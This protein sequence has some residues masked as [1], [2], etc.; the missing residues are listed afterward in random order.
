MARKKAR[1]GSPTGR[2][3]TQEII[4]YARNYYLRRKKSAQRQPNRP[5]EI[6]KNFFKRRRKSNYRKLLF[7]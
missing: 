4:I 6:A 3:R 2:E 1:S 5:R 7:T